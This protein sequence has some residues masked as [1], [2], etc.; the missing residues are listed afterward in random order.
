MDL[1][2]EIKRRLA[3]V[4]DEKRYRHCLLTAEKADLL[5]RAHGLSAEDAELAGLVHDIAKRFSDEE[6]REW[7]TRAGLDPGLLD[8]ACKN[9]IHADVGAVV[10]KEWFSLSDEICRAVRLHTIPD[11]EMTAFDKVI[12][13]ADKVGRENLDPELQELE[14]LALE[15]LDAAMVKF[16]RA[17]EVWL[18][19]RG[20]LQH[21]RTAKFLEK[22]DG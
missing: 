14:N 9:Y 20:L 10:A 3:E 5:A 7:V 12:F 11:P 21:P 17:Q 19:E 15:D 2:E 16:L 1:R 4:V 6:N 13:L 8:P 22:Y 18:S